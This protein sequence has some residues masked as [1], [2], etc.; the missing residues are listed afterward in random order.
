[1]RSLP[2][3]EDSVAKH[4]RFESCHPA[5]VSPE[6]VWLGTHPDV[7]SQLDSAWAFDVRD[8]GPD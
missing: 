1:M 8:V 5:D 4:P 2:R 7:L 6:D 3:A